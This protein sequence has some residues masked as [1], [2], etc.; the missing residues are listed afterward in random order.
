MNET[1]ETDDKKTT[2]RKTM[3]LSVKR[4]VEQGHIRQNFSHGRSKSVL[5]ETKRKRSLP[6]AAAAFS[7]ERQLL[8]PEAVQ[9]KPEPQAFQ[10]PAPEPPAG[11]KRTQKGL[12]ESDAG[13]R[14]AGQR[15]MQE[16]RKREDVE[17]SEREI[18]EAQRIEEE[19]KQ[20]V[21]QQKLRKEEEARK[22]TEEAA[23]LAERARSP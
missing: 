20:A 11:D 4:T 21:A 12:R 18:E 10:K 16:A 17:K 15:A 23:T 2:A 1:K 3:S 9:R 22:A 14:D 7:E 13:E 6:G 5:V 8:K 19:K